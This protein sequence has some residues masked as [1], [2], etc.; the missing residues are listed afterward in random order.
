MSN[1]QQGWF[2]GGVFRYGCHRCLICSLHHCAAERHPCYIIA[3]SGNL[4][5]GG[6]T[7]YLYALGMAC[8]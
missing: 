8:R 2:A 7:L 1:R 6:G 5:L 3:Q 4:W